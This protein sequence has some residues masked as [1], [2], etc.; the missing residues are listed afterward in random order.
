MLRL[1]LGYD[2][3]CV[4]VVSAVQAELTQGAEPTAST[5][6]ESLQQRISALQKTVEDQEMLRDPLRAAQ[7]E[8]R[9]LKDSA[10]MASSGHRPEDSWAPGQHGQL[11][12]GEV[13]GTCRFFGNASPA[14]LL[15]RDSEDTECGTGSA[16]YSARL[17]CGLWPFS[18]D[19]PTSMSASVPTLGFAL[20]DIRRQLPDRS[21]IQRLMDLY[22]EEAACRDNIAERATMNTI[23]DRVHASP[24]FTEQIDGQKRLN[25]H[26]LAMV[27]FMAAIGAAVDR[28]PQFGEQRSHR[29]DLVWKVD[30]GSDTLD[31]IAMIQT[32]DTL[33]SISRGRPRT[34]SEH[35][36]S[37]DYPTLPPAAEVS[38][39][40][41]ENLLFHNHKYRLIRI[42]GRVNDIQTRG[43]LPHVS[44]ALEVEREL[45]Q[46]ESNL[47]DCLALHGTLPRLNDRQGF[48]RISMK[49][50]I[51][52]GIFYTYRSYFAEALK[53][54]PSEPL[55]SEYQLAYV[56][57]LDASRSLIDMLREACLLNA[58]LVARMWDW[59]HL[60]FVAIATFAAVIIRSPSSYFAAAAFE[61]IEK[62][63]N[64]F[65][66][67]PQ[68][69]Q[70]QRV[71]HKVR[72]LRDQSSNALAT[73]RLAQPL[74]PVE[75]LGELGLETTLERIPFDL[76]SLPDTS[77]A[78]MLPGGDLPTPGNTSGHTGHPDS[79]RGSEHFQDTS[80]GLN[81]SQPRRLAA[82]SESPWAHWEGETSR[83]EDFD[84][85]S[86]L[87]SLGL[88]S[89]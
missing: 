55:H 87:I 17:S 52:Q 86:F 35:V 27:F 58:G 9:E 66:S 41:H 33:Q 68:A 6:A 30:L 22:Y 20:E 69:S 59:S 2:S 84:F 74:V 32:E 21:V 45:K 61:Q 13:A 28:S 38:R 3:W 72:R 36:I 16:P 56:S 12:L 26:H 47:P 89:E 71:I 49:L 80:L 46:F 5:Y 50:L 4:L 85:D 1:L 19:L 79:G 8:I 63:A 48:Q 42:L 64:L 62:G 65:E 77:F 23:A 81:D 57:E 60:A 73:H 14:Y 67:L 25:N 88:S 54:H 39:E 76:R 34:M 31:C 7:K 75:A 43:T 18:K 82:D 78:R 44:V 15:L 24:F 83:Q 11:I 40:V 53:S 51:N 37:S 10:R 70:N 29:E